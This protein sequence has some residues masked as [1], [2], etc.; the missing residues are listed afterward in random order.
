MLSRLPLDRHGGQ[1]RLAMASPVIETDGA[2]K[3]SSIIKKY[4]SKQPLIQVC[5]DGVDA[6]DESDFLRPRSSLDLLLAGYCIF[7]RIEKLI[8]DKKFTSVLLSK[9]LAYPS[10]V[11]MDTLDQR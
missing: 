1:G 9:A 6:L 7:H 11:L 2:L 8:I 4:S 5:P 10:L 3:Q